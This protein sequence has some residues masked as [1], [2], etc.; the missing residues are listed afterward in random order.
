MALLTDWIE[1]GRVERIDS[2]G[3]CHPSETSHGDLSEGGGERERTKEEDMQ[4]YEDI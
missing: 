2:C 1:D 4:I 3:R